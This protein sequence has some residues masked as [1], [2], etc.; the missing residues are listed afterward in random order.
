MP[1]SRI[2][3]RRINPLEFPIGWMYSKFYSLKNDPSD[4]GKLLGNLAIAEWLG[5]PFLLPL[6]HNSEKNTGLNRRIL[7]SFFHG[8]PEERRFVSR[9]RGQVSCI[10]PPLGSGP[11]Q[12]LPLLDVKDNGLSSTQS[13]SLSYDINLAL[14]KEKEEGGKR[15]GQYSQTSV[16]VNHQEDSNIFEK[17]LADLEG[18]I[19]HDKII[20]I[21]EK[22]CNRFVNR[23]KNLRRQ[24]HTRG[25]RYYGPIYQNSP[26]YM[27]PYLLIDGSPTTE[28]DYSSTHPTILYSMEG[29]KPPTDIYDLGLPIS[30]DAIKI[31]V[32]ILLNANSSYQAIGALKIHPLISGELKQHNLAP[33]A[34]ID[35]FRAI[36]TP[37]TKYMFT[38]RLWVTLQ[39][40]ESKICSYVLSQARKYEVPVCAIHDSFIV[41]STEREWLHS[42]MIAAWS[43][44]LGKEVIP[45]IKR[46]H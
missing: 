39:Y 38:H 21:L 33:Q 17:Q 40:T 43:S 2:S 11:Q 14:R 3:H 26:K 18:Q 10:L 30:R 5:I 22:Y 23:Q 25:G 24:S 8:F 44:V 31:C 27:R 20:K 42:T 32:L 12:P 35:A 28:L 41:P 13:S 29:R 16:F 15:G 19:I 6:D 37:I 36:H 7:H 1:L 34:V 45:N 9:V 46:S 4:E